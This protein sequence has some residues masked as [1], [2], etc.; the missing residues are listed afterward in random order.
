MKGSH[1]VLLTLLLISLSCKGISGQR[2]GPVNHVVVCWLRQPGNE[3]AR[4]ELIE[5]SKSFEKT[6]PGLV[7]VAAGTALP[8]T[9]PVVDSTYDVGIVMIFS[10]EQSLRGFETHPVHKQ[11]VERTLK[12]LVERFVVY[13]FI[14]FAGQRTSN[15]Q[16]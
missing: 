15:I 1:V 9:R 2:E 12:P 16:Y 6:I 7:R 4:R 13:D 11:A 10:N 14:D 3:A 8:S 5:A